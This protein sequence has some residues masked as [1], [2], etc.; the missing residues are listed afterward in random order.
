MKTIFTFLIIVGS[1]IL[2]NGQWIDYLSYS[3]ANKVIEAESKIYCAT[4]GGLFTYNKTDNSVEKLSG[5]NGLSDVGIQTIGYGEESGVI[6]IAYE[7]SNVDLIIGNEVFNLSDI[8]R[9]Q[10]S[11]DKK[12]YN[13][14]F[15]DKT[16]YLSCGFG[17]VALNL[18]KKEVKDTYYIGD[19]G[20]SVLVLDM[21]SDGQFL[22]AATEEGLFKADINSPNLQ[23]FTNWSHIDNI[24]NPTGIFDQL[25]YFNGSI[26]ANYSGG[27]SSSDKL[28][29]LEGDSWS[30]YLPVVTNIDDIQVK[31]STLVLARMGQV[32][33]YDLDGRRLEKIDSYSFSEYNV[34]GIHASSATLDSEGVLWIADSEIGL[35]KKSSQAYELSIPSGP[36]DNEIFCLLGNGDDLWVSS[37]G[38]NA[39]W[40]N[41]FYSPQFQ[42]LREGEWTVFNKN[43]YSELA[44]IHDIV[45]MAVDPNDPD[46]VFAGSWGGGIVEFNDKQFVDR[47]NQFNS[48]LQTALPGNPDPNFV[49]IGGMAFDSQGNL[50]ATNALVDKPL[51]VFK[52]DGNWESFDFTGIPTNYDLGQIVITENDDQWIVLPRGHDL[53]VRKGDG[54]VSKKLLSTAWFNSTQ[55]DIFTRLND[56][57]SIAIDREGE[58][59]IGTSKGVAVYR[60]PEKIWETNPFYSEQPGLD[61]NDNI[62]HPLLETETVTAIAIN[63]ANR[64]WFGTKNSGVFLISK[65]GDR[66]IE[67]FTESNSPL[68]SNEIT[69]I[70]IKPDGEVF[71]GT[72]KGLISFQG[73]AA[74]PK[75]DYSDVYAYPNPVREDYDGD[76]MISGLIEDTDV[77]ITDISGNLVY[78][79][80]S[81]GG[82]AVWNG[83]NLLGNRVSTGVYMVLGND[84]L[85]EQTFVTKILFIH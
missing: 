24:Q 61:L 54:S 20:S 40:N 22:Y 36:A 77:K 78:E 65:N 31:G 44:S 84:K 11:G 32:D 66:E 83:R 49:R 9:K 52:T 17:I 79:T 64:K 47:Y 38:R 63:G 16:A 35:V 34:S 3:S 80:K 10:I 85:G 45:C 26:I 13:I 29:R 30:A 33:L 27:D 46:H 55:G 37:G 12:I 19:N 74:E 67:H 4:T 73:A 62:Y 2:A 57:Y 72:S 82:Q 59:W 71:F 51:S 53:F 81:L 69:S 76:I 21:T 25:E 70:S 14:L 23:D 39:I 60:S 1:S 48:S 50:W 43:T 56:I 8:K 41:L 28:Y 18:D 5:I 42:L 6:L 15:I 75:D 7:N 68:L 58:I